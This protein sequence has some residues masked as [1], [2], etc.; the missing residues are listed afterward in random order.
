MKRKLSYRKSKKGIA[1]QYGISINKEMITNLGI[2]KDN[3]EVIIFF[4]SNS[5]SIIIKSS[6]ES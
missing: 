5:K 1:E 2:T 6:K 4:D 3:R